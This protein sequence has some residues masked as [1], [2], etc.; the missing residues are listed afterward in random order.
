MKTVIVTGANSGIGKATTAILSDMGMNV[1]M[2]C[3]DMNR[4]NDA[5]KE[6]MKVPGRS[7]D[8]MYCDLADL[9]SIRRFSRDFHDKYKKLDILINN[10]GFIS[11]KREVTKDGFERQF[12][13]NHLG[14]FLLTL[15]L[16][17]L[18]ESGARIINVSSGAHKV[19]KIHFDDINL[20]EKYNV[21]K[22]YS[23]SKLANILFTRELAKR[24]FDRK[25][26]VNS[27]FPGAVAT[28]I[29][30]NREN[31]FGKVIVENLGKFFLKPEE[32]AK[33]SV[34][35]ATSNEV[36]GKTGKYY[37]KCKSEP[38]S[39]LSR[40]PDLSKQL[41]ELSEELTGCNFK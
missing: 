23:Q 22:A 17:D 30:I 5:Y 21:I 29:G 34:Y 28:N 7:L 35:L 9:E 15:L 16:I 38:T 32:G 4:G 18:M 10:A 12:G 14:H 3:R 26:S 31:G 25:I 27:C 40:D 19:G 24:L 39:I 37:Y 8:L 41:F 11:L 33:T 36:K 13:V 20:E 2:L 6:L 1:V